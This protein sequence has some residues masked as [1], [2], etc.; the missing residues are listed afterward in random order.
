MDCYGVKK[1]AE[2]YP[3]RTILGH[4]LMGMELILIYTALFGSFNNKF[5]L[6]VENN[7]YTILKLG[8]IFLQLFLTIFA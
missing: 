6:I 4:F 5:S 2:N 8:I 1:T 7:N 3:S